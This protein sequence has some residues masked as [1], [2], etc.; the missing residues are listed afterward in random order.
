MVYMDQVRKRNLEFF[1]GVGSNILCDDYSPMM[2]Q[3]IK[4]AVTVRKP[5]PGTI[6][7]DSITACM[8]SNTET[9]EIKSYSCD[10]CQAPFGCPY[11]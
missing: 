1:L 4:K 8:T 9:G 2:T 10:D 5:L 7:P 11:K 3:G 6:D